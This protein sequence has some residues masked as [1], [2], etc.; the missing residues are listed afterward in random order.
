MFDYSSQRPR[1]LNCI[2]V[3]NGYFNDVVSP[4]TIQIDQAAIGRAGHAQS[5]GFAA[6]EVVDLGD[7]STNGLL[8]LRNLDD[9]NY[10]TF[11]PQSDAATIEVCGKLEPGEIAFFRLAPT[12]V[13]W[14]Q[15]DTA[16]CLLDVKLFED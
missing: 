7:V 2:G 10:V 15:A 14:A 9:T 1:Y 12:I 4:G 16:A 13:L 5:I 11:G 6:P 3:V 8:Y